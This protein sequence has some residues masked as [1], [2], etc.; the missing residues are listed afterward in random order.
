M[1][2]VAT[3]PASLPATPAEPDLAESGFLV[4]GVVL[5]PVYFVLT[6]VGVLALTMVVWFVPTV[7]PWFLPAA[8]VPAAAVAF[9]LPSILCGA[10]ALAASRLLRRDIP[11]GIGWS[12]AC[13]GIPALDL[14]AAARLFAALPRA[15]RPLALR[16]FGLVVAASMLCA[17]VCATAV[18]GII[19]AANGPPP[20]TAGGLAIGALAGLIPGFIGYT[21]MRGMLVWVV[22]LTL[23][24]RTLRCLEDPGADYDAA[25]ARYV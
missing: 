2:S 11:F 18:L 16:S 8:G 4:L 23:T 13:L 25:V 5:G 10:S 6:A 9:V 20:A 7:D 19:G 24:S 22:A 15:D 17:L 12:L 3:L 21:A 14:L 1:A